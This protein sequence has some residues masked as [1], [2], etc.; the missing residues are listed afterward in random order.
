MGPENSTSKEE[1]SSRAGPAPSL[2]DQR[3]ADP[4]ARSLPES[5]KAGGI[6]G[7]EMA[8]MDPEDLRRWVA[9]KRA[10]AE[11]ERAEVRGGSFSPDP[12]DAALDLIALGGELHGWPMSEDPV[13][14]REDELARER[15]VR[16]RRALGAR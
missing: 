1:G 5:L 4:E 9:E 15:W 13:T 12:I 2:L 16:L 6:V 8:A 7:L 11:R 3:G 10:A 14:L